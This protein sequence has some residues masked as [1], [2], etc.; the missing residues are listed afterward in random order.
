MASLAHTP[1]ACFPSLSIVFA[2]LWHVHGR[3]INGMLWL[4]LGVRGD[5]L[6]IPRQLFAR[7]EESRTG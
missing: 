6:V 1:V 5:P 4:R 2:S 7:F 3:F